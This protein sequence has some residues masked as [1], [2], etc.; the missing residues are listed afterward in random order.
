MN[1]IC[2]CQSLETFSKYFTRA[3]KFEPQIYI[4]GL[5][6]TVNTE[7]VQKKRNGNG[8]EL[9]AEWEKAYELFKPSTFNVWNLIDLVKRYMYICIFIKELRWKNNKIDMQSMATT[10]TVTTITYSKNIKWSTPDKNQYFHC[11]TFPPK[12]I[13]QLQTI[14][15]IHSNEIQWNL[16]THTHTAKQQLTSNSKNNHICVHKID[17]LEAINVF[18]RCY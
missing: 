2:D 4:F 14:F 11:Q 18:Y 8:I 16:I 15:T 17:K 7:H 5:L 1:F 6:H 3:E 12:N 10:A 9:R 13:S